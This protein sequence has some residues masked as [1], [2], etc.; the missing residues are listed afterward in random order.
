MHIST[1]RAECGLSRQVRTNH[2]AMLNADVQMTS[3]WGYSLHCRMTAAEPVF[4]DAASRTNVNE[5][6]RRSD[7]ML[8]PCTGFQ[9]SR[10]LVPSS[11][12]SLQDRYCGHSI[13][14]RRRLTFHRGLLCHNLPTFDYCVA[15]VRF[16][17]DKLRLELSESSLYLPDICG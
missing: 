10:R 12:Q 5:V 8:Q 6:K 14:H 1:I 11:L 16:G 7:K 13:R 9:K 17:H 15:K 4:P 2:A 3:K